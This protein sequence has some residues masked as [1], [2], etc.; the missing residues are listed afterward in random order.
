M[1][2]KSPWRS[3]QTLRWSLLIMGVAMVGAGLV[4]LFLL[5]L[6]T[7]NRGVYDANYTALFRVNLAVAALL[8]LVIAWFSVRLGVRLYQGKFGSRLLLKLAAIFAL[9]GLFRV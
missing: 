5:T 8:L 7:G 3:T 4:L 6:A 9:V 1:A 2:N